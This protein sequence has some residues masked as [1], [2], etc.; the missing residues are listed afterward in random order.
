MIGEMRTYF[1]QL[2][3]L[4]QLLPRYPQLD[5]QPLLPF[6]IDCPAM[7]FSLSPEEAWMRESR[8]RTSIPQSSQPDLSK[9]LENDKDGPK[10]LLPSMARLAL[11]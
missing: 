2:D 1:C 4:G 11:L 6:V 8:P 9:D 5:H 7:L 3:E 10:K